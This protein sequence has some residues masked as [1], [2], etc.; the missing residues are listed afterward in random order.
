MHCLARSQTRSTSWR[1]QHWVARGCRNDRIAIVPGLNGYTHHSA[2]AVFPWRPAPVQINA[3]GFQGTLGAEWYDYIQV[4]RFVAPEASQPFFSG[5]FFYM[6][7][8]WY[9]S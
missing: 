5:R 6:P 8:M 1:C 7:V 2:A 9:P 4:D 3:I